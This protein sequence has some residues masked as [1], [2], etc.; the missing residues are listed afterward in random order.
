MDLKHRVLKGLHCNLLFFK[1]VSPT[2][3]QLLQPSVILAIGV[4]VKERFA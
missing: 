2:S 3:L 1:F 4:G